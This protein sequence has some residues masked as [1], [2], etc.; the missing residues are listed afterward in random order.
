MAEAEISVYGGFPE[1]AGIESVA[2]ALRAGF[3]GAQVHV[4]DFGEGLGPT[5]HFRIE[6]VFFATLYMDEEAA[7][8]FDGGVPGSLDEAIAVVRRMSECL[9]AAGLGHDFHVARGPMDY[10]ASFMY[11]PEN[12]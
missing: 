8:L 5:L 4:H 7:F 10:A 9:A 1:S 11:P 6:P 3:P 12:A 2:A